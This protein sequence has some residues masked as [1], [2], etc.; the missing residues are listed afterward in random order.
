MN[1]YCYY[2]EVYQ[3]SVFYSSCTTAA[4]PQLD[5]FNMLINNVIRFNPV[6]IHLLL[7]NL[8]RTSSCSHI[9]YITIINLHSLIS[10]SFI[11]IS[12]LKRTR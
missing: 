1:Q 10:L 5:G 3:A 8:R 2:N 4:W 7:W 11:I 9:L 6:I 12:F